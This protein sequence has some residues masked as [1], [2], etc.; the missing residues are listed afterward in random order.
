MRESIPHFLAQPVGWRYLLSLSLA[1][2]DTVS[3][4]EHSLLLSLLLGLAQFGRYDIANHV[5]VLGSARLGLMMALRLPACPQ[6]HE[7]DGK[8]KELEGS[9]HELQARLDKT[10]ADLQRYEST[11]KYKI[12]H[13]VV[14]VVSCRCILQTVTV[15]TSQ[16][17][18]CR[19]SNFGTEA[20][21]MC[22]GQE[23]CGV[24]CL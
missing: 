9:K 15:H 6:L 17:L 7:R 2:T 5:L 23:R 16:L 21:G 1:H 10:L 20:P 13:N 3:F 22:Y 24:M 11:V 4:T 18:R 19:K 8:V 12:Y 14:F